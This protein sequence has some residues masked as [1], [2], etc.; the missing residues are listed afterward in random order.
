LRIVLT[1]P[2]VVQVGLVRGQRTVV[3]RRVT[4]RT[5][6]RK[7][8]SVG[9]LK[10]ATYAVTLTATDGATQSVDRAALRVLPGR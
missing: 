8:I 4:F 10:A 5:A 3:T 1:G 9:R 6:G 2:A 7:Q